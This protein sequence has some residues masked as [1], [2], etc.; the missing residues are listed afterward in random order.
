MLR[1][2]VQMNLCPCYETL[3]LL[4]LR[5]ILSGCGRLSLFRHLLLPDLA[6]NK[7]IGTKP[8]FGCKTFLTESVEI[9]LGINIRALIH[10][11]LI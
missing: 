4:T 6:H 11:Q 3:K 1:L 7:L 8:T 10:K 2:F 5:D 9:Y